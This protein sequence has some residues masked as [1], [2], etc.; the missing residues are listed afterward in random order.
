MPQISPEYHHFLH[1]LKARI[2]QAQYEALKA[3]NHRQLELYWYIGQQ[4]T[5]KQAELGW[6]KSVVEQL[7]QDLQEAFPGEGGFSASN[8]WRMRNWVKTYVGK[9]KL[10]PLVREI[11]WSH[12]LAIMEK[13]KTDQQR[14][15]YLLMTRKMGWSKKVLIH[16]IENQ[17]YEQ[18][19]LN[20]TNFDH[21]VPEKYR[22][23]ALLAI[24]DEY[25]FGLLGL[26]NQHAEKE[27]ED[28]LVKNIRAFLME[29]GSY[30]SFIG[31]QYRLTVEDKEY[32]LDLLLFHRKLK[33]L[34]AVELKIGEFTPEMAG[35]MQFYLNVLNDQ[36]REPDEN[37][38]IGIIICKA[39]NRTVVEYALQESKQPIGV[40]TYRIAP[41]L[42]AD[43][44]QYLPTAEQL[45]K[46]TQLIDA[47]RQDDEQND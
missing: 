15:F 33:A 47:L 37:P 3:V 23:Q 43:W 25:Q 5:L 41:T 12:N 44:Q 19:L 7:A 32:F 22:D 35:K 42:P 28:A 16:Q 21:T 1:D 46:H 4:I 30:F 8:L 2:R 29:M 24:K 45:I 31:N 34:V 36:V 27:L 17:T 9:E 20:Q 11:G 6:G 10:A 18:Y 39:K 14:E 13:C 38:A 40:A 26:A